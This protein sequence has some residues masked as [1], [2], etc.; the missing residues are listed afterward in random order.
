M[1]ERKPQ[2]V[3][4]MIE[5]GSRNTLTPICVHPKSS[6]GCLSDWRTRLYLWPLDATVVLC[7]MERAPIWTDLSFGFGGGT[8]FLALKHERRI[9]GQSSNPVCGFSMMEQVR[10]CTVWPME[11]WLG[12]SLNQIQG[13]T[14]VW[15]SYSRALEEGPLHTRRRRVRWS[16]L[17]GWLSAACKCLQ[18][19]PSAPGPSSVLNIVNTP[20]FGYPR[21]LVALQKCSRG[22][23]F[24]LHSWNL[25]ALIWSR[26]AHN[27]ACSLFSC[28]RCCHKRLRFCLRGVND[29]EAV[30]FLWY[31]LLP[32][33]FPRCHS[34]VSLSK[35]NSSV[36]SQ[37]W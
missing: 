26:P 29:D 6:P 22:A 21:P 31:A 14:T 32:P 8:E 2:S 36:F 27:T 9:L 11:N 10:L 30:V 25:A 23:T 1:T 15:E 19:S 33:N 3:N 7:A 24:K 17:A 35:G 4:T 34:C 18:F 12:S 20:M 13:W 5:R 28:W 16:W 37:S